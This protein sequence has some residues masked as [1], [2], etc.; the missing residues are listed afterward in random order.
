MTSTLATPPSAE[1]PNR[2]RTAECLCCYVYRMVDAHGCA[3]DLRWAGRWRDSEAP[4]IRGLE[5]I[6][7]SAGSFCDCEVLTNVRTP[8]VAPAPGAA[9]PGCQALQ[10][11][12]LACVL[13][14]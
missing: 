11:G 8:V 2:P 12:E 14:D 3:T 9:L 13:F 4:D 6:L 1:S 7:R 5:R 10:A